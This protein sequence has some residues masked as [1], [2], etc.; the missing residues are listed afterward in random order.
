MNLAP[1]RAGAAQ[2]ELA[3]DLQ[4][5]IV[6]L[7]GTMVDTVGDFEAALGGMCADLG[8]GRVGR[9]FIVRT[10]GKGS[11]NLVR[12]ALAEVGAAEALYEPAWGRYQHHYR[13]VNGRFSTVFPGV[14][15]GLELLRAAGLALAC[16]TNKPTEHA[17]ALL[18]AKRLDGFFGHVFGGDA[19]ERKKPDPLPLV[20]T[21]AALGASPER[22]LMIGDS[23]NDAQA[24]D[25]A[26]CPV[27]L[28]TYGFNHGEPVRDVP[29]LAHLERI[30]ALRA[31]IEPQPQSARRDGVPLT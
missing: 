25:A 4:A 27:V 6:D 10:I 14:V 17:R 8:L 5:A 3:V 21:C 20:R 30:D 26:G 2:P 29:A 1:V 19:F 24:A 7:D 18:V 23:R 9:E 11:E 28:V 13:Q 12:R 16:L 15:E 31:W 22:T